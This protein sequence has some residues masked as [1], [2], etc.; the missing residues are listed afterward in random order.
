MN[1]F[2]NPYRSLVE[3]LDLLVKTQ[4]ELNMQIEAFCAEM[5]AAA[6]WARNFHSKMEQGSR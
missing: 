4:R 3:E 2:R 6:T 1:I 5:K